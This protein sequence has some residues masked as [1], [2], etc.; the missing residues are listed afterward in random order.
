L[1]FND[2]T[3]LKY[4]LLFLFLLMGAT[5]S[6]QYYDN[7]WMLGGGNN[8]IIL[9]FSEGNPT[10]TPQAIN[11]SMGSSSLAV[12]NAAGE[13]IFYTNGCDIFNADHELMLN[14]GTGINPGTPHQWQCDDRPATDQAYTAGMQSTIA[15]PKP[16]DSSHY[17]LIH[18]G[19]EYYEDNGF[20][21]RTD[22]LY[23]TEID[24]TLDEGLGGI[25]Q[26]NKILVEDTLAA[27]M[28]TAVKHANGQDWW[29]VTPQY[30]NDKFYTWRLDSAGF[31]GP[32]EQ[33][34]GPISPRSAEGSGQANFSPDGQHY[35]RFTP[36]EG[37]YI[38]DFDRETGLLSNFR[39]VT[40]DITELFSGG[41]AFAPGSRLL[42][43]AT[44]SEIYQFDTQVEDIAASQTVISQYDSIPEIIQQH[45]WSLQVGPDCRLYNYCNSC[46]VMHVIEHPDSLGL[47]SS[48]VQAAIELP[49]WVF[50]SQPHYPNYRLGPL[51]A[52]GLPCEPILVSTREEELAEKRPLAIYPNPSPGYITLDWIENTKAKPALWELFDMQGRRVRNIP[53]NTGEQR[54]L[55]L[56]SLPS[57]I[58]VWRL[59]DRESGLLLQTG[60]LLLQP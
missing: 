21:V 28:M 54:D 1:S 46:E 32:F 52:E 20:D 17:Y 9:N 14:N 38:Y 30:V 36:I 5:A 2:S 40:L 31:H 29:I 56:S 12:S 33:Q 34:I 47:A 48:Y 45:G 43:V 55:V 11:A 15:L 7:N 27:G 37:V 50:R 58:Y 25:V 24:M 18:K 51:G 60:R 59:R 10:I 8:A 53:V 19:I 57:G 23:F 6:S 26:R 13:L 42:Y 3:S 41:I 39:H 44:I 4:T 16:G 49:V 22:K 35:V